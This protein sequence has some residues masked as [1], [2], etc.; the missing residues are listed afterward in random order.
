MPA[1]NLLLKLHTPFD[2]PVKTLGVSLLN[3]N[4]FHQNSNNVFLSVS[5]DALLAKIKHCTIVEIGISITASFTVHDLL[6]S[7]SRRGGS[8]S[9][10][11]HLICVATS[12][13]D[14]R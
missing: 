14:A 13:L 11:F 4:P 6:L 3:Q 9:N 2:L 1:N 7:I 10:E 5:I 12:G 8:S